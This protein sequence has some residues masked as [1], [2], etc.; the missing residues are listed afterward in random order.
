MYRLELVAKQVIGDVYH[1]LHE[2]PISD[3]LLWGGGA[4][5]MV[6]WVTPVM[7]PGLFLSYPHHLDG[8]CGD[9]PSGCVPVISLSDLPLS[10]A[11]NGTNF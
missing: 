3:W 5:L 10:A 9:Q 7:V 4:P 6:W 1:S 2:T 8:V 11:P